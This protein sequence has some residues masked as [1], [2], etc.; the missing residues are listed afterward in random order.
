AVEVAN[1]DAIHPGYGFLAESAAFAEQCRASKIEF[2][3]PTAES[4][5][6]LGDKAAA[7]K[8]ARKCKVAC[9][10]G[11]LDI[12]EDDE[13][14]ARIANEIRYPVLIKAAAGRGGRGMP[15]AHNQASL[16]PSLHR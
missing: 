9:V 15:V 1:V 2:I 11:S 14:A 7:K 16:R 4:I 10:P 3:G 12:V 6:L 8:L 5:R 13:E